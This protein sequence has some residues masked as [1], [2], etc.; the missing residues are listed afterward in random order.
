MAR[1]SSETQE[2]VESQRL[3][4]DEN[5]LAQMIEISIRN[6]L[7]AELT[8]HLG[9]Q[10]YERSDERRGQRNGTK[11]RTMNSRVGKL[12]FQV[13]QSR[14][15]SFSPSVFERY[16][17]SERALVAAMQEMMV[18]GVSTR[19]VGEVLEKMAGFTVSPATVSR[20]MA[21]LDEEI[22]RFRNRPLTELTYPYLVIDARY[23]KIRT[24]KH[25]VSQAVLVA[26]GITDAGQ[27]EILGLWVDNSESEE[28]WGKVFKEL[29]SRGLKGVELV[30]SDA[31]AGIRA[32]LARHF[33][34]VAWQRCQIHLM[35]ELIKKVSWRDDK[36]LSKDLR[37]I[38]VSESRETC[39][40]VAEEVAAKWEKKAPEL[41]KVL[42]AGIE[43]CLTVQ[44]MPSE[45]RRRLRSTN[46]LER[47]MRSLKQR[48]QVVSIFPNAASCQRLLGAVLL[49]IHEDW[50][51]AE[52][53]RY[54]NFDR[55]NP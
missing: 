10:R 25:V 45:I 12:H 43:D 36:E 44:E 46:M 54:L 29:R 34:G 49:D 50:T 15:S 31:H 2:V 7:E 37:A 47:L 5:S 28:T 32:A 48:S 53:K 33:Q 35:R 22:E 38:F 40:A 6:V 1:T 18:Q 16:Q 9:A 51:S 3:F 11:P 8:E 19:R 30:V 41:A 21:E 27:R 13:P 20:S 17:R 39:L 4:V 52:A 24:N 55:L 14:D 23:E 42:R 26:A